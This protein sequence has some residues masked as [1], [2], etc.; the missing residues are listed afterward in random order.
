MMAAHS[1]SMPPHYQQQQPQDTHPGSQYQDYSRPSSA[2]S[3]LHS[4][5]SYLEGPRPVEYSPSLPGYPQGSGS[6]YGSPVA[7]Q[8]SSTYGSSYSSTYSG[9]GFDYYGYQN[10]AT[11]YDVYQSHAPQHSSAAGTAP[12]A[13]SIAM[14]AAIQTESYSL[15][16]H[17]LVVDQT[18]ATAG[19]SQSHVNQLSDEELSKKL[20]VPASATLFLLHNQ[21]R[22]VKVFLSPGAVHLHI[23]TQSILLRDIDAIRMGCKTSIF[24]KR[25]IVPDPGR[26]FSIQYGL[27]TLDLEVPDAQSFELWTSGLIRLVAGIREIGSD[28]AHVKGA[29]FKAGKEKLS[30]ED[31]CAV[32]NLL[33]LSPTV[34]TIHQWA[35]GMDLFDFSSFLPLLRR[36][37][38]RS[39]IKYLF[40][41]YTKGTEAMSC[42]Q[43]VAFVTTEQRDTDF[44]VEHAVQIISQFGDRVTQTLSC[45]GF[46]TYL[47][48]SRWNSFESPKICQVYQDM[49]RPLHEYFISSS[50]KTY[51]EGHQL[52]GKSSSEMYVRVLK[53]GCRCIELDCWDGSDGE[54]V[55]THG[56]TLTSK[57]SF[58]EVLRVIKKFAFFASEYPLVLR[59]VVV[60]FRKAVFLLFIHPFFHFD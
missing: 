11:S 37:R 2:Y 16:S 52:T 55:I 59:Y 38:E 19:Q 43:L 20:E 6:V 8:G 17:G 22:P 46:E 15:L 32:L 5:A 24:T 54:P 42:A 1:S 3:E 48:S 57:I 28:Y 33:G 25:A 49:T 9:Y 4:A 12:T 36:C 29:W 41:Q 35:P 10:S 26:C 30:A 45:E 18:D 56:N 14:A 21:T 7:A 31:V 23:G 58:E 13:A 53:T 34:E 39:E 44:D 47:T 27:K 50:H 51:L 40:Y 60:V